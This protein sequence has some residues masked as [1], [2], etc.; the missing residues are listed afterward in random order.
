MKTVK[1]REIADNPTASLSGESAILLNLARTPLNAEIS[2]ET[3]ASIRED[4]NWSDLII[5]S[6]N[7]GVL[8]LLYKQLHSLGSTVVP[9]HILDYVKVRYCSNALANFY[10][11]QEL[12]QLLNLFQSNQVAAIPYKGPVLA[13]SAYGSLSLRQF[14]DLDILVDWRDY[15]RSKKL[16]LS[17]GFQLSADCEWESHFISSSGGYCLD[18][19]QGLTPRIFPYSIEF[20]NLWQRRSKMVLCGEPVPTLSDEDSLLILCVQVA[21]DTWEKRSRLAKVCDLAQFLH[22]HPGLNWEWLLTEATRIG[23]RGTLSFALTLAHDLLGIPIPAEISIRVKHDRSI[24]SLVAQVR[25]EFIVQLC[26]RASGSCRPVSISEQARFH[27]QLRERFRDK[28]PYH[29]EPLRRF[30]ERLFIPNARDHSFLSLPEALHCLYG[31]IRPLRLV[32]D[33]L[34]HPLAQALRLSHRTNHQGE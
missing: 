33:Y 12:L 30:L 28:L 24:A 19:H 11:A 23:A 9:Q 8:P 5:V 26:A 7:H 1:F 15:D 13:V 29:L 18:L 27:S 25:N 3:C 6:H 21:K 14:L 16:L 32:Y 2:P 22:E 17:D 20:S 34:L 31:L 4:V 10:L